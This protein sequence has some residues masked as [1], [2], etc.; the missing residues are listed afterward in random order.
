VV[1]KGFD[2]IK[3]K[4]EAA[5]RI[6]EET[7]GMTIEEEVAYWAK[8]TEDLLRRQA[9]LRRKRAAESAEPR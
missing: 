7:K 2:C 6:Y 1:I 5:R 9:E 8:G 3:S 4:H